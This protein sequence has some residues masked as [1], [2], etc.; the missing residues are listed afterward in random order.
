MDLTNFIARVFS[1]NPNEIAGTAFL[2]AVLDDRQLWMTCHHVI[3][4]LPSFGLAVYS[5]GS[6][7]PFQ[8]TYCRD[9]SAPQVDIAILETRLSSEDL[10]ALQLCP[11]PL[12]SPRIDVDLKEKTLFGCGSSKNVITYTR[13]VNF[14]GRFSVLQPLRNP[15]DTPQDKKAISILG[16]PWNIPFEDGWE[17]T[18]YEFHDEGQ[19]LEKGFSGSPV[20]IEDDNRGVTQM[21]I[22]MLSTRRVL[23]ASPTHGL[24]IPYETISV[25]CRQ[26]MPFHAYAD[27]VIVVL[28]AKQSEFQALT[29]QLQP[30]LQSRLPHYDAGSREAWK[31]FTLSDPPVRKLLEDNI[32]PPVSWQLSSE[33]IDRIDEG[34]KDYL[35]DRTQG[36]LVYIID[37]CSIG[38]AELSDFLEF[39]GDH[40]R[41]A[42]YVVPVCK[43]LASR[44]IAETRLRQQK[45]G[46]RLWTTRNSTRVKYPADPVDFADRV[47]GLIKQAQE[48]FILENS[49]LPRRLPKHSLDVRSA[50]RMG[51]SS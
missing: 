40:N 19:R 35:D 8:T 12:G 7:L 36:A 6:P 30:E 4:R 20:C 31:P 49:H 14:D 15:P 21:C 3:R 25:F 27:C 13:G 9:L 5:K 48:Q 41:G 44:Q 37:P 28:A 24:V 11:L 43:E 29:Q 26:S 2:F 51:W 10:A 50:P 17:M 39:A 46:M 34:F 45:F 38:A 32:R 23:N 33:Y 42:C 47:E 18:L 22:G 16:Q 1:P